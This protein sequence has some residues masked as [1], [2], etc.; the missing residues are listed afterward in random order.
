MKYPDRLKDKTEINDHMSNYQILFLK[1]GLRSKPFSYEN[2]RPKYYY[3][4]SA[5]RC[6]KLD[7]SLLT[8]NWNISY[9][10][11]GF[12]D[13]KKQN[14]IN[15]NKETKKFHPFW[16]NCGAKRLWII[17][18]IYISKCLIFSGRKHN[19][20]Y[21]SPVISFQTLKRI[22]KSVRAKAVRLFFKI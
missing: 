3:C 1:G 5:N 8:E 11:A 17:F 2:L 13:C 21:Q 9:W 10:L 15:W 16:K 20:N 19:M 6:K 12:L 18:Y 14:K 7:G 22:L 4:K